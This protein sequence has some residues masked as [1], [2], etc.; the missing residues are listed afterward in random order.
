MEKTQEELCS[1][2]NK[3]F[4][5]RRQIDILERQKQNLIL[6]YNKLI[7]DIDKLTEKKNAV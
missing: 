4:D 3:A 6:E 5:I 1:K 2:K 7:I